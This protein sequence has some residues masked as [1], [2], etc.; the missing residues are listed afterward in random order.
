MNSRERRQLA[1]REHN[2][3][4]RYER[5]LEANAIYTRTEA[6]RVRKGGR[7]SGKLSLAMLLALALQS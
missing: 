1:A 6:R 4:I 7:A 3:K 2:D 5:W